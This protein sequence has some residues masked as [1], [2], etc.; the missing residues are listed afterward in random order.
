MVSFRESFEKR[1]KINKNLRSVQCHIQFC[2]ILY[3]TVHTAVAIE[4]NERKKISR[5]YTKQ[6]EIKVVSINEIAAE[7]Q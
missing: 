7:L 2:I 5:K 3:H 4:Q 1:N 6:S